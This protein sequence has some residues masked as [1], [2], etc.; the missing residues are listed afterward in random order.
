MHL[1][2]A[3]NRKRLIY[4]ALDLGITHFDTARFYSDGLSEAT[5][6]RTLEGRREK[7]TITTKFGLLPTPFMASLGMLAPP[8]RKA[9]GLLNKLRL[10]SYP[11]RSYTHKVLQR[12]LEASL[13]ALRSD[14]VDI[15]C[16]H[17]PLSDSSIDDGIFEEL[18]R[19]KEKGHLRFIGVAGAHID[20]IVARYGSSLDV[21]Q[22]E[23][24]SWSEYRFVPDISHSLFSSTLRKKHVRMGED[25]MRQ[26]LER[27]LARRPEGS[28]IVQ[29]RHPDHLKQIVA[30]AGGK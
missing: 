9:R 23:E 8:F 21:I 1:L 28:V 20:S 3:T 16:L 27:A 26:L 29:T 13:R 5:L 17:E 24:A 14:Y 4:C 7:V 6:G 15:Y 19:N 18:Q 2:S 11:R 12:D 22:S 10:I 30:W 25:S